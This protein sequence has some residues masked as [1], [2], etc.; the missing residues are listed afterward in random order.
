[1]SRR[2]VLLTLLALASL[3]V[4]AVAEAASS[5][6]HPPAALDAPGAVVA[7][8]DTGV[9][10]HPGLTVAVLPGA[11]LVDGDED[12]ADENGHGTAVAARVGAACARCRI[13]PVRVLSSAGS[14]PWARVA[15][16]VVWAVEHGA[17][18]INVS[19]AGPDGSDE[20]RDAIAYATSRDVLVVASAGNT[21]DTTPQYPAA[22]DGVVG[23]AAASAGGELADWSSRGSWVDVTAPGCSTLPMVVGTY[24]WACGT[25]FAAP[26]AAGMAALAR[27][28]DPAAPAASIAGRLPALLAPV[29]SPK[30]A[31]RVS[32]R[33]LPGAVLRASASGFSRSRDLGERVHWLRC[34]PGSSPHAC[35]TVATGPAY[36][37]RTA[38]VG[39]TLVARVV[40]KPF[41]GLWLAASPKLTVS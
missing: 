2:F 25:S 38:D 9:S 28:A 1:M 3:S 36:R 22:Y 7:V 6:D 20:L 26:L 15:A 17:S 34:A 29:R 21:G 24:A 4:F 31:L 16:G 5:L 12:A 13:L 23:I 32:G 39:W 8:L 27:S 11:D 40:T 33:P 14:A 30:G 41:G 18:V 10:T 37:V 35:S 19:I